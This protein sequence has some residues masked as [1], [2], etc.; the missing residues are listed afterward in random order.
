VE[1]RPDETRLQQQLDDLEAK[2]Q[3]LKI[4]NEFAVSLMTIPSI[5]ELLWHVAKEVVGQLGFADCVIYRLESDT[6]DLTQVAASGDKNT[7]PTEIANKI[8]IPLGK[9]I[10]GAVA[11]SVSPLII[12]DLAEDRRYIRDILPARSEICVP[13]IVEGQVFGVID[14]ED[15]RLNFFD[16]N[17]LEILTTVA[18]LTGSKIEQCMSTERLS[19]QAQIIEQVSEIVIIA[20]MN[21]I[22]L[23]CN[24]ATENAYQTRKASLVGTNLFTLY[25]EATQ[26]ES[27]RPE[28]LKLLKEGDGWEGRVPI[29]GHNNEVRFFD[30]SVNTLDGQKGHSGRFIT[31]GREVTEQVTAQESLKE[32]NGVLQTMSLELTEALE[33]SKVA[34]HTQAAF[35]ANVS[36]ELRTPL[37]A[38]V[39]FSDIMMSTDYI[40]RNPE[41]ALEYNQYIHSAGNHLTSLVNDILD[42]SSLAAKEIQANFVELNPV[43]EINECLTLIG[44]KAGMRDI[45]ITLEADDIKT[46][47]LFDER[48]FKQVITN[49]I[50]NAIKYS[51]K[52]SKIRISTRRN[53]DD[54]FEISVSDQGNGIEASQL[55]TIFTAFS[56]A[57]WAQAQQVEG[58]GLGLA[59]VQELLNTNNAQIS[60]QSR[61]G[62]GST[63]TVLIAPEA[64][65]QNERTQP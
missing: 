6:C 42:I 46:Q 26:I 33:Q 31:V 5:D 9:G 47:I 22:V 25:S 38:I 41:K 19:N 57:D 34:Q 62:H 63:F 1:Q 48:H 30:I 16:E 29:R 55:D 27:Q 45:D 58:A 28:V 14:C 24:P 61:P 59:L 2:R 36:H 49:L 56:R 11:N 15:V 37:N 18:S 60:V 3:A 64:V 50:D 12:K 23:D 10:T 7:G 21:G 13:L 39:G 65:V 40:E 8:S 20:D 44:R 51:P 4:L 32:R 52:K 54:G 17:H 53:R 43:D 35:L